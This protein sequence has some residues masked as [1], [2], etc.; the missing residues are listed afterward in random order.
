MQYLSNIWRKI[1]W[2]KLIFCLQINIKCFFKFWHYQFRCVWPGMPKLPKITSLLFLCNILRKKWVMKL[3][4]CMKISMKV[5]YKLILWF[6]W[7]WSSIPKIPIIASWQCHL[8]KEVR[9]EVDILHADEHQSFLQVDVKTLGIKVSYEVM[10]LL[11]MGMIK[12][13]Q[14]TQGR[15]QYLYNISKKKKKKKRIGM[16]FIFCI[17]INIKVFTS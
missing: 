10:L 14:S 7:H 1:W 12:H 6:S 16:E 15:L 4:F 8:K 11:L 13:S 2:I 3:I 17:Q 5:A 9:D